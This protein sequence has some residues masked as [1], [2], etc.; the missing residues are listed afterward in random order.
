MKKICLFAIIALIALAS[1]T[2][3]PDKTSGQRRRILR[4]GNRLPNQYIVLLN[5]KQ[6][7]TDAAEPEVQT[8]GQYLSGVYGGQVG[9]TYSSAVKGFS[10]EMTP[11]QA[12][13][14]NLDPNVLSI[15]EDQVVSASSTEMNAP[16]HLDRVDQRPLPMDTMYNYASMGTGVNIYIIDSGI[17]TTHTDFGGRA[18]A[19]YDAI[20]DGQNGNDCYGHGTH[21]A[22][23]AGS[24]T[25]GVAKNSRLHSVRVLNCSG[26][27]SISVTLAG[28]DW[29]T[30]HHI[31][32]AVA[33]LS[34]TLSGISSSV[35]TSVTNSINSGVTYTIAS[36]NFG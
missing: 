16:W 36:G 13:K 32:P 31:S 12:D 24:S 28:I 9:F 5:E 3:I 35:D 4:A 11:D 2:I 17:R 26:S 20:G 33:N 8:M 10:I 14:M 22:G 23:I 25:Y 6:M 29:V 7:S 30:A 15:E 27:G 19:V 1:V 21:V 34:L 18:D